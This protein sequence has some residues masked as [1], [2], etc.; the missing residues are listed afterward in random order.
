MRTILRFAAIAGLLAAAGPALAAKD[1]DQ[2]DSPPPPIFQAVADCK[3]VAEP[4]QRLAC[5]DRTVDAMVS[6][7]Q[8]K[9]LVVADRATIREAKRGLFGLRLPTIKLF[10]G[11]DNEDVSEIESTIAAFR[12]ASDGLLILVVEDGAR[13]KQ[14][15]GR[16][17]YPKVGDKIRIRRAALGSFMANIN[18]DVGFKV[19]R[20]AN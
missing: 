16:A 12:S 15:D 10:G 11:N 9:D 8:R 14:T 3:A 2:G 7:T 17:L 20:L 5:Y 13:W 6:A 18:K 4:A 19:V 1:K